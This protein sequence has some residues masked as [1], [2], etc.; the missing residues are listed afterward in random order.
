MKLTENYMALARLWQAVFILAVEDYH[1][2][3]ESKDWFSSP[4]ALWI[5]NV[6]DLAGLIDDTINQVSRISRVA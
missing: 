2:G 3:Q 5:L 6:L 1:N 4:R